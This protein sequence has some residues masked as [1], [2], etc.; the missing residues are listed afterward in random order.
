MIPNRAQEKIA[1][2][3]QSGLR[4]AGSRDSSSRR[5]V[6]ASVAAPIG[7]LTKKIHRQERPEV[8]AP[9][10]TGPTATAIPEIAPQTAKAVA[11]SEPRN[12]SARRA[13][14]VENMIA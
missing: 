8:I 9:P 10:S 13:S 11:R 12:A 3:I 5:R 7:T 14:E 2:P 4:A 1:K 6:A